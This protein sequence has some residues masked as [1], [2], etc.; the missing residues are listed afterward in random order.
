MS[1]SDFVMSYSECFLNLTFDEI[2]KRPAAAVNISG[3]D[4]ILETVK[5]AI[6]CLSISLSV[7][8]FARV[9]VFCV[10]L[11]ACGVCVRVRVCVLCVCVCVC[12]CVW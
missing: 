10:C 11:Y 1:S 5:S 12:V 4:R 9:C 7:C 2:W 3:L 6:L 8:V